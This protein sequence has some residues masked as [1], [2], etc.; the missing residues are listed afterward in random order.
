MSIDPRVTATSRVMRP[1]AKA[2]AWRFAKATAWR[3]A[4]VDNAAPTYYV[5]PA[6]LRERDALVSHYGI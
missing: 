1:F 5:C 3:F 6:R 2:T 4:K